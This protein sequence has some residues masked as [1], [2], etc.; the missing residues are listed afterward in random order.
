MGGILFVDE[1]GRERASYSVGE[2]FKVI[3]PE[4]KYADEEYAIAVKELGGVD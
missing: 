4:N 1:A 3:V 2:K